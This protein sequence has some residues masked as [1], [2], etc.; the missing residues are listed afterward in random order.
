MR[1]LPSVASLATAMLLPACA[2]NESAAF[3]ALR[4]KLRGVVQREYPEARVDSRAV[5]FSA[6][7]HTEQMSISTRTDASG[8]FVFKDSPAPLPHGFILEVRLARSARVPAGNFPVL[9]DAS[10]CRSTSGYAPLPDTDQLL[11]IMF[12]VGY[13]VP[14][15]FTSDVIAAIQDSV[16]R[17]R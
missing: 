11:E 9:E 3:T 15:R 1:Y 17:D 8:T 4:S 12:F 5:S 14:A 10:N 7:A 13:K 6:S 2:H 16:G